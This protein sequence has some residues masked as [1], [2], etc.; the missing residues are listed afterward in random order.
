VDGVLLATRLALTAILLIASIAKLVD[1]GT[2]RRAL[3]GFGLPASLVMPVGI[4]LP[5]TELVIALMLPWAPTATWGGIAAAAL[6]AIFSAT[7]GVN[8]WQGRTPPC[9][10]F[11]QFDTKPIGVPTLVRAL[12]LTA[13]AV[14]VAWRGPGT[15]IMQ[16]VHDLTSANIVWMI[17]VGAGASL[18]VI[19]GAL[20]FMLMQQHGRLLIRLE[21]LEASLSSPAAQTRVAG[22]PLGSLAP[23][24]EVES[25]SRRPTA[26]AELMR[27]ARPVVLIFVDPDCPACTSLST[28]LAGWRRQFDTR[29][30]IAVVSV[31]DAKAGRR[32]LAQ[33][34]NEDV[35]LQQNR[36]VAD[37]YKVTGTPTA[38]LISGTRL[39]GSH[40]AEGADAIRELMASL[41][42]TALQ[43]TSP[44][45]AQPALL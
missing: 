35:Y 34:G 43:S 27:A 7:M 26:L 24:F 4:L 8:L 25:P 20:M 40:L 29:I 37:L 10:C 12:V 44:P 23:D 1:V 18:L 11:G 17:L 41:E 21:K 42:S 16:V 15:D 5:C 31:R 19:E 30:G 2:F 13:G 22:L 9:G 45:I 33:Y 38:V 39:I 28:D 32:A 36:E 6:F 3:R 14:L